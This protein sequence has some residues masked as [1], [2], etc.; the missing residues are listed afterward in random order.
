MAELTLGIVTPAPRHSRHGNRVSALRWAG[1]LRSLGHRPF[2]VSGPTDRPCDLLF[3]VHAT[4]SAAAIAHYRARAPRGPLVVLLA[5]TDLAE[6]TGAAAPALAA[7]D[8]ILVLQPHARDALPPELRAKSRVVRQSATAPPPAARRPIVA[9]APDAAAFDVVVLAHL[10]AVKDPFRAA[11]AARLLPP[12]S[13]LRILHAG[14]ALDAGTAERAAAEARSNPRWRWLGELRHGESRA[15]L[16]GARLLLLTSLSE[17]GAN[18]VSEALAAGVPIVSSRIE[19]ST[20]ILGASYPGYFTPGDEQ[21]LAALLLRCEREP[22]FLAAL[23]AWCRRLAPL[24]DPALERA[25]LADLLEELLPGRGHPRRG[26]APRVTFLGAEPE[27]PFVRLAD[28]VRSGLLAAQ[29]RLPCCW[30]YDEEG[31]RLFEE[32]C[33]TP[34]YYVTRAEDELLKT[35]APAIVTSLPPAT[36]VVELGSGSAAKTRRILDALAATGRLARYVMIDISPSALAASAAALARDYPTLPLV[37][38]C[39]EYEEG[40]ER[41]A[42]LAPAPRLVLWLGSNVGN[43]HRDEAAAFLARLRARLAPADRLLLGIDLR[44]GRAVLEPAYDDAAGVTARFNQN[45]LVRVNRELGGDFDVADFR[46]RATWNEADGRI[47]M[48]LDARRDLRVRI[49]ALDLAVDFRRGEALHTEN[50]YKYSE[51]EIDTL[52]ERAGL[53]V[54]GRWFDGGRRVAETLLLPAAAPPARDRG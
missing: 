34:E 42:T 1:L 29:K 51:A 13:H 35:H 47:E 28:D 3:A 32:I 8:R 6:V 43:F 10:R 41:L 17:G 31:S 39:A 14:A 49:T 52:A 4:K 46:H 24:A 40:L 25:A 36:T 2:V 38:L 15:L 11:L 27:P 54:A 37:A 44:K 23:G 21:D 9:A 5:G 19:G 33:A 7:A 30:F 12:T 16:A 53:R 26:P 20:G 48:W 45:L 50:S 18:V 22:A